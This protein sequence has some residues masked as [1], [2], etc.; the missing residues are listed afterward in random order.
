MFMD[1]SIRKAAFY[2]QIF[3]LKKNQNVVLKLSMKS[4]LD[5]N[6]TPMSN[7]RYISFSGTMN[8]TWKVRG[9]AGLFGEIT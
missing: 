1:L 5:L 2:R 4:S 6:I 3:L 8:K 9:P 7:S